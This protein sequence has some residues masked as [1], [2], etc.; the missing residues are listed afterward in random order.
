MYVTSVMAGEKSGSLIEVLDRYITYQKLALAVR[1]KVMVS[2]MYPCVLVVL[3][4]LLMVFLVTYVVPNFATLYTSMQAKLPP[5]T[6]LLMPSAPRR[7]ATSWYSPAA[8]SAASS[9]SA[10]GRAAIRRAEKID[11]VKIA[12]RSPARSG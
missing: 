9:C 6:V 8:W 12:C 5:M 11:R 1:K 7:A 4:S 2:L 10:G 3:V